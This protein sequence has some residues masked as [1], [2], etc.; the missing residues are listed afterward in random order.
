MGM[1]LP[2]GKPITLYVISYN[3]ILWNNF[4]II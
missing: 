4:L 2:D 1:A 3:N